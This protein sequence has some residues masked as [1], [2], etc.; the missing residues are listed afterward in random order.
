M[1]WRKVVCSCVCVRRKVRLI[2]RAGMNAGLF[3]GMCRAGLIINR[4]RC[5]GEKLCVRVCVCVGRY[6]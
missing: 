2:C 6:I 4:S 1:L 3:A 5:C